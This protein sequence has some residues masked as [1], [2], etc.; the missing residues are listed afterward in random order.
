MCPSRKAR[1]LSES[2]TSSYMATAR[3]RFK[4]VSE[5]NARA[6]TPTMQPCLSEGRP[7]RLS[8]LL[9]SRKGGQG[10]GE[11]FQS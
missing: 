2:T 7:L 8:I 5:G 6:D 9:A 10:V 4:A 3:T 1:Q 11:T